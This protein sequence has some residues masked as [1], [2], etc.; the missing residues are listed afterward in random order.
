MYKVLCLEDEPISA[1]IL[2]R[3]LQKDFEVQMVN[4]CPSCY[5]AVRK[6]KYDVV[7][8]DICLGIENKAGIQVM[9]SIRL[10]PNG[11]TV[12]IIVITP[13]VLPKYSEQLIQSGFD[14]HIIMPISKRGLCTTIWSILSG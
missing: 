12:K 3:F 1:F 11:D 4:D 7:L 9:Q 13:F 10:I 6:E 14:E 2:E 5:E 8:L